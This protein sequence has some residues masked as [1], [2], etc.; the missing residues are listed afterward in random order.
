MG[1][2]GLVG[3]FYNTCNLK[4]LCLNKP[5]SFLKNEIKGGMEGILTIF[6]DRLFCSENAL[7]VLCWSFFLLGSLKITFFMECV[8]PSKVKSVNVL[9][10]AW[11]HVELTMLLVKEKCPKKTWYFK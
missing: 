6:L 11:A 4:G 1:G 8:C 2:G 10:K 7:T 5:F 3:G 9:E